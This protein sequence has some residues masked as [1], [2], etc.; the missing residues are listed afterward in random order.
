[1]ISTYAETK[2]TCV[3]IL[4]QDTMKSGE[5]D[6]LFLDDKGVLQHRSRD[7]LLG[8]MASSAISTLVQNGYPLEDPFLS[9]QEAR[10]LSRI[11]S[12]NTN[13]PTL[14]DE[15]LCVVTVGKWNNRILDIES[16]VKVVRAISPLG[17][18]AAL[19]DLSSQNA[20]YEMARKRVD[21]IDA[22]VLREI[23]RLQ[24]CYD[25]GVI[26]YDCSDRSSRILDAM[27]QTYQALRAHDGRI[28]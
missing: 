21:T 2:N 14:S 28:A 20:V 16:G 24:K 26:S 9:V 18:H 12:L 8:S 25:M 17:V 10:L 27:D 7:A 1:M 19:K 5:I 23:E 3:S 6:E 4:S 11:R 15:S 13:A 22:Q